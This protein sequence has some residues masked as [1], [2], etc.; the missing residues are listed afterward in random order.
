MPKGKA[1]LATCGL[2]LVV[3]GFVAGLNY[4]RAN[5]MMHHLSK[6]LSDTRGAGKYP[7]Y[8]YDT[9]QSAFDGRDH[10]SGK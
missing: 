8:F 9:D 10:S 2:L 1:N 5:R 7:Q 6:L 3:V 4:Y